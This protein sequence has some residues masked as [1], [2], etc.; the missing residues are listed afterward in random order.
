FISSRWRCDGGCLIES[1]W[2]KAAGV[3]PARER[4]PSPTGFEAR[5]RHR[6]RLPSWKSALG[7]LRQCIVRANVALVAEPSGQAY[8]VEELENLDTALAADTC[9]IAKRRCLNRRVIGGQFQEH[10]R[11]SAHRSISVKQVT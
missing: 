2:R 3:E 11:Q 7:S 1:V 10:S 5:P 9:G 6:A 4:L 8:T